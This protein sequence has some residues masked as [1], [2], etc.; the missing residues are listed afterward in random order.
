M[1]EMVVEKV[2]LKDMQRI[3][4]SLDKKVVCVGATALLVDCTQRLV[5]TKSVRSFINQI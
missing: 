5:V 2:L 3:N 4:D 1:L